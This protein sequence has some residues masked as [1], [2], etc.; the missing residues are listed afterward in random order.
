VL[1]A[2]DIVLIVTGALLYSFSFA[3]IGL[4]LIGGALGF[5]L[6]LMLPQFTR[7][8]NVTRVG[9]YWR[10]VQ[11]VVLSTVLILLGALI[12]RRHLYDSMLAVQQACIVLGGMLSVYL[13]N[14]GYLFLEALSA[15]DAD[16][17]ARRAQADRE[18]L[19]LTRD[20]ASDRDG[21]P[22]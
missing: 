13:V 17:P 21:G 19:R 8:R 3:D 12:V 22:G 10:M 16:E 2:F 6:L 18:R 9:L 4:F 5:A 15:W 20:A 7:P 14:S 11:L 1:F